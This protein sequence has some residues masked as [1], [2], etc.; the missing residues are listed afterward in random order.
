MATLPYIEHL[1]NGTYRLHIRAEDKN[2]IAVTDYELKQLKR[3]LDAHFEGSDI[4]TTAWNGMIID[5]DTDSVLGRYGCPG[6]C[7]FS[8]AEN[9]HKKNGHT[10][11]VW[12]CIKAFGQQKEL[13]ADVDECELDPEEESDEPKEEPKKKSKPKSKPAPSFTL[14]NYG[15]EEADVDAS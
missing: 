8:P 5:E 4:N 12:Q 15:L 1:D 14:A 2:S 13:K 9:I 11:S 3:V 6:S 10:I 7:L